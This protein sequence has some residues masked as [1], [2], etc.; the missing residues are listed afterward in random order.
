MAVFHSAS[1]PPGPW[2]P[3]IIAD[4]RKNLDS[5]LNAPIESV[6]ILTI[7]VDEIARVGDLEI[8]SANQPLINL[9]LPLVALLPF[10]IDGDLAVLSSG[11]VI[12]DHDL[13]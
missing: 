2:L 4:I 10:G 7:A 6:C 11:F 8:L 1:W 5:K 13:A 3:S 9:Y 12:N